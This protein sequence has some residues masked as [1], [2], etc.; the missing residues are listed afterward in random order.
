VSWPIRVWRAELGEAAEVTRLL[1]AFRD[2]LESSSPPEAALHGSV[3]RLFDDPGTEFLLGAPG[4]GGPPC[5]ICQLRFRHSVWTSA[6]DCWLEDLFVT[7]EGRGQGIG[8]ALVIAA[9]ERARERGAARI[10]LD[11]SES[12]SAAIALYEA[13]GF[14]AISKVHGKLAGR[15]LFMGRRL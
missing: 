15:D 1:I 10:E 6:E 3:R 9:C 5:G 2:W 13:L 8:R 4:Q 12:N 14:S 11:T 7:A